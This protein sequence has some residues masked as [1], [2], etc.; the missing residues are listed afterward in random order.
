MKLKLDKENN[1]WVQLPKNSREPGSI[2]LDG[3]IHNS[4]SSAIEVM[5][6]TELDLPIAV[7]GYPGTGKSTLTIQLASF[8]DPTF[9]VSRM[10]VET[11]DFIEAVKKAKPLQ[12]VVLDESWEAFSSSQ[13][14]RELGRALYN[15]LNV[16]RQKRLYIFIIIPNFF[17]LSKSIALFRCRWLFHCYS[18]TFGDIGRVALFDQD[19]K[20][21]LFIKGK[22]TED[23]NVVKADWLCSFQ[24]TLP[25]R[26]DWDK[27]LLKKKEHLDSI[28][29][30]TEIYSKTRI[31]RN[32]LIR[33]FHGKKISAKLLAEITGMT[34][35][36]IYNILKET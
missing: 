19:T 22:P 14:R 5:D 8:C 9:N 25:E 7:S 28:S 4:F 24:K 32:N 21:T 26:F 33:Y 30:D 27:Y 23:Y 35:T 6:R 13:M 29:V 15:L 34:T 12:A 31:Q 11:K 18:P 1:K 20:H 10:C 16:V 17:D 2:Y 3:Y 36:Q